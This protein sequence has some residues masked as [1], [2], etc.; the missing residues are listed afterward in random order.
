MKYPWILCLQCRSFDSRLTYI[1][2]YIQNLKYVPA[3]FVHIHT[4]ISKMKMHPSLK[5]GVFMNM[6][7]SCQISNKYSELIAHFLEIQHI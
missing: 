3:L 6:V 2:T 7:K 5:T 1:Y 4:E